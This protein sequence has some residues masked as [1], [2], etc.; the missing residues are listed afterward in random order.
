MDYL[1][2]RGYVTRDALQILRDELNNEVSTHLRQEE[3]RSLQEKFLR[4]G[5]HHHDRQSSLHWTSCVITFLLG[6][7]LLIA[8]GGCETCTRHDWWIAEAFIV[9]SVLICS[10]YITGFNAKLKH[11]EAV[12][13]IY[14]AVDKLQ[15][16]IRT[17][18]WGPTNYL[19]RHCPAS[20]SVS[21][22]WTYRDN[23]VVN[24]P[25]SLLVEGDI[26][27]L[28]PGHKAPAKC[29]CLEEN[30]IELDAD[31]V[32]VP[33][34]ENQHEHLNGPAP[35][36]PL[37]VKIFV[38]L[39][40]PLLKNI[41]CLLSKSTSRPVSVFDNEHYTVGLLWIQRIVLPVIFCA[42]V[43]VN[44]IR[45][46][47]YP[48][49]T[50][51]WTEVLLVLQVHAILPLLPLSSPV[52]W[53]L[54]NN[55]GLA[56]ILAVYEEGKSDE[57]EPSDLDKFSIETNLSE[58]EIRVKYELKQV[59]MNFKELL[60]GC[61]I[62][63]PRTANIMHVLSAVTS[64]CCVDKKGILSWPNPSPEKVFFLTSSPKYG[65]S[66]G[67]SQAE[68]NDDQ[69]SSSNDNQDDG[70]YFP[71]CRVEVLDLTHDMKDSFGLHFDYPHWK[72]YMS[73]LKPLGLN[74]LLNTCNL[75]TQDGYSKFMDHV[76]VAALKN[77]ETVLAVVNRRCIC[78][79][80][81]QIGF[82]EHALKI[83]K[84]QHEVGIYRHLATESTPRGHKI[85]ASGSRG[86]A[87]G[88][89]KIPMSNM[90]SV[91]VQEANSGMSQLL[92]QGTADIL[93]DSCT[94]FW[95]GT[96]I[97]PLSEPVRKKILDFYQRTSMSSYCT[98]FSYR[99]LCQQVS[100]D[101]GDE[102]IEL[103]ADCC[104][105]YPVARSPTPTRSWDMESLD[106]RLNKGLNHY[107]S[108]D[109][110]Y[111]QSSCGSI[112]D[113]NELFRAQCNQ[114]FIGMVASQYQAKPDIVK[115]I[116]NLELAC[117]R[118]VHFSNENELRSRVFSEKMGL[119][120][121]WNCH[122]SL[123]SGKASE[124]HGSSQHESTLSGLSQRASRISSHVS[125]DMESLIKA[126]EMEVMKNKCTN[127]SGRRYS[128]PGAINVEDLQVRFD[129]NPA[130]VHTT[131]SD[132]EMET[133]HQHNLQEVTYKLESQSPNH[134]LGSG[135]I[136]EQNHNRNSV[137]SGHDAND[138]GFQDFDIQSGSHR[139]SNTEESMST[140]Y[141][142]SNR[143]KLPK[144]IE[145]IR[146][147][148]EH[149]DNVPLLVPLFTDCTPE[150]SKEMISVMQEYG[151]VVC[152][153]GSTA[154]LQN[155]QVFMQANASIGIEPLYSK[156]CRREPI[157]AEPWEEDEL[158][159][160][161]LN[162]VFNS[163]GCSLHFYR[164]N[165]ISLIQLIA[166]ARHHCI[167]TRNCFILMLSF[168]I[169]ISLIQVLTSLLQ[170]P[171][172][173]SSHH[174]LWLMFVIVPLLSIAQMGAPLDTHI[175]SLATGKNNE[176]THKEI[177]GQY[178]IYYICRFVPSIAV[179]I[180]CFALTLFE[181]CN[182]VSTNPDYCH[183]LFGNKDYNQTR[184]WRGLSTDHHAGLILAQNVVLCQ[185]VLYFVCASVSY[186]HRFYS[187]WK[188]SPTN[189]RLW[190][191]ILPSVL[192][193]QLIFS[194]CDVYINQDHKI[195]IATI[196]L[197]VWLIAFIWPLVLI[198]ILELVKL[199]EIR[200]SVRYQKRARLDFGTKLGMNSPF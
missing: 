96:D 87:A 102:Y 194:L 30:P 20:P 200:L 95:D 27:L 127:A 98:A 128:A 85:K 137:I 129:K 49:N 19:S 12:H 161:D 68:H 14:R 146:P 153:I 50:G 101:L 172:V 39:E 58:D 151:E 76:S 89:H 93:M 32:Y 74:M 64:L 121:G 185:L 52:I 35:R 141:D 184:T 157:M 17:C 67:S 56:K 173:L 174:L 26:I 177:V 193:L 165:N 119:E 138:H 88:K 81:R 122:I 103:P 110:L 4:S 37:E 162:R 13:H 109:S 84:L 149:V 148:L 3:S 66:A 168:H 134:M 15:D 90:M 75:K 40:T 152:C 59:W 104:H 23:E 126:R 169:T 196:P 158:S 133:I 155:T 135:H 33:D 160:M 1:E 99:P 44:I 192:I 125:A 107:P 28:R 63:L 188:R 7:L 143:A 42:S 94:E 183:A 139:T 34:I 69:D 62:T 73:S 53:Y 55:Y 61:G 78:E 130:T 21:T 150:T 197:A 191:I 189:N 25:C 106:S 175:M 29:R 198:P 118:F 97:C 6:V 77:E 51:H 144:G 124:E 31:E 45:Y 147:H 180:L 181:V 100:C 91:I 41:K 166:E 111:S 167:T 38:L 136:A 47:M 24:L 116:E 156:W 145:N 178:S 71:E 132:F 159:P 22:Q 117:I 187:L 108:A 182:T 123:L 83:F 82:T 179:T 10:M 57:Y 46:I 195:T 120:A 170:L 171:P 115:L 105:L 5:F 8:Y 60:F 9:L 80:A 86:K 154:T 18:T 140:G 2:I 199:H 164:D 142:M 131:E 43:L 114:I 92:S 176:H 79:V 72:N 16:C 190:C 48:G 65:D 11:E 163:L 186:A 70:A 112:R 113:P 54:L 36:K